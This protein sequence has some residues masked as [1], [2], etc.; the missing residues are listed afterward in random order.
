MRQWINQRKIVLILLNFLL[1][2]LPSVSALGQTVYD[3]QIVAQTGIPVGSGTPIALGTGPSIN[4]AGKV[5]FIARDQAA[6]TGRVVVVNEGVVERNYPVND[7]ATVSDY[8]QINDADQVIFRQG[9]N[10]NLVSHIQRLDTQSGGE[11]IATGSFSYVIQAPFLQVLDW[12]TLNN[13]GRGVFSA[14][15]LQNDPSTYEYTYLGTRVGGI[16]DHDISPPLTGYPNLYPMIS[17]DDRIIFR[18]GGSETAPIM[19]FIDQKLDPATAF[20]IATSTNF[21]AM[22]EQP[23]I[24][25]DGRVVAF[26][27]VHKTIYVAN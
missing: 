2:C 22:G 8:V 17:N 26:M 11:T 5:A 3:L 21:N 24:S 16:G 1:L 18:G 23:G 10:D 13:N 9:F 12:V 14:D 6:L 20:G 27:G 4:D 25:D 7:P 15:G 19:V